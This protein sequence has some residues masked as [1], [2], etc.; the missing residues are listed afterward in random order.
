MRLRR[1]FRW[2]GYLG[3][4]QLPPVQRLQRIGDN[5]WRR[6]SRRQACCGRYGEPGC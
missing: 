2:F 5:L 4:G 3:S 6:V 1:T